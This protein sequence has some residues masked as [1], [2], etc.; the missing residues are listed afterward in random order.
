MFGERYFATRERLADVMRG[1]AGLAAE[2]TTDL[3]DGLPLAEIEK[4]LRSPFVF[5]VSG[6]VNAGKSTLLNGLFGH[7]LCRVSA[8]PETDRVLRYQHAAAA[9][10]VESGPRL[11]E[12]YRPLD[13]LRDFTLIDT[14]GTNSSAQDHQEII[15]RLLPSADL[16]LF[17]FPVSNPW[18][19]ATWNLISALAPEAL[20]RVAIIIQQADQR[21]AKDIRVILGHLADL[22][23]KRI[24][25]VPPIF[26]V[27]GKLAYEAKRATPFA[28]ERLKAS[29]YPDLEHFISQRIC[30]SP[31]RRAALESCRSQA[32]AALR[33]VEDHLEEQNLALNTQGRFL[34]TIEREID[35]IRER[36]VVQLPRHLQGVAEVFE[37]EAVW[38]SKRLR[39]RLGVIRSFFRLFVGDRTGPAIETLFIERLQAAVEAVAEKD[40]LEVVECCRSHWNA[41]GERVKTAMAVELGDSAPLDT[42]LTAAKKRFVQ[43]LG[44][45]ARQGI[46]NL[47][48]RNQLDKELRRRNLALKSFLVT[49]LALT[50]V[51]ASCGA[52]DM[53][54]PAVSL[55]GLAAL[56]LMSGVV[57]AW[58]TRKAITAEFQKRL[59][60][61]C[62]G[63]ASTLR[64]D[65]EE[66][67]R[68]VFQDYATS[69]T[70][71]RTHL[72]REKQAIQ[73]R[74]KRWQELFLT[75]KAIEQE[76]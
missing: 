39:R 15:A 17:V 35:D 52:L 32:A 4:E 68:V 46:G 70:A 44:R 7:D 41:L 43:R 12:C 69:L 57:V 48:V 34:D 23:M 31:A 9:R 36:F 5:V 16:I 14:P 2:T 53:P 28:A 49:T 72:V 61:T 6:E 67:L 20:K 33:K 55:C 63:F 60:N 56:F 1:I 38:V 11:K 74:L 75:L 71:V 26:A 3:G 25:Q 58:V 45:A 40:S 8:L 59:L 21:E 19:A 37:T 66:A 10:D 27:S 73:P 42:T 18:G 64:A 29:G 51:G 65:Y 22:S 50:T 54:W 62:G 24:G 13:F 47:K 30:Q 76:L